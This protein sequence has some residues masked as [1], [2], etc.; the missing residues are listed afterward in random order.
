MNLEKKVG[1]CLN[2]Q[3]IKQLIEGGKLVSE[4]DDSRIQ[5]SS[6]EPTTGNEAFILDTETKGIFRP[7]V[8]ESVYRTLLQLPRRRR[9]KVSS[10]E[11]GFEIK[12]GFT[13]LIP[14]N[15]KISL[16][17]IDY[18]KFSPK[19]SLG[20]L[21][22]NTR[23]LADYNPCLDEIN[24]KY[25]SGCHLSLWLLL[26]PLAFNLVMYP[27]LS[28]NQA[29]FFQGVDAKL[30][31]REIAQEFEANPLLYNRQDDGS[32]VPAKPII[33]DE[34]LQIHLDL[35]GRDTQGI[36]GLRARRNPT[37]VDLKKKEHYE[38]EDFFEPIKGEIKIKEKEYYL[39]AS[40]EILKTPAHLNME[41]KDHSHIGF[42]G[43]LHFAGFVDNGFEGD[44]VFEVRSDEI[45]GMGLEH[46]MPI[47][48]L[49]IFRTDPPKV[50][51]GEEIGSNYK[52]QVGPR[53]PKFFKKFDFAFAAK[54]Y[55]KLDR[56]VLV[57]DAL[58]LKKH[59]SRDEGFEHLTPERT[60]GLYKDIENG[61][62]QSRYDCEYDELILQPIPYVLLF[63]P[64]NTIFSYYIGNCL[65]REVNKEEVTVIGSAS[66][67]KLA[68]T[69]V[70][71]DKPI[72]RV[73]FGLVFTIHVDGEVRPKESAIASG[74][75]VKI[76]DLIN[77]P[78]YRE[79]YETWSGVL[80]PLLPS[81]YNYR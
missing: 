39:L 50:V 43:P 14:L 75:M 81:L 3:Q 30:N 41:L 18:V 69:L 24:S 11:H 6:F 76:D 71:R 48:K 72:D 16:E 58:V 17:G 44:L 19:S 52:G 74:K 25:K 32:L 78:L 67:P 51:Y 53:P 64:D 22:L 28:L 54:N 29:R 65:D 12:Q 15:E 56:D 49:N 26:Q 13:Y 73:H 70:H 5:P 40:K 45:S 55:K 59:R 23:L 38:A 4:L 77:D 2:S 63:G 80:I 9:N 10:I 37:P 1:K 21:F 60:K 61:F 7:Q 47:S 20:R 46:G 68:G 33:T 35:S 62:F 79:K 42:R 31:S 57:Q 66:K 8:G 34:G 27:G 36:V